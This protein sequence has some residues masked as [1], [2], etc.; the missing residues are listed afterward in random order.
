MQH[1]LGVDPYFFQ[2][3][4]DPESAR[5]LSVMCHEIR[6]PVSVI[7]GIACIL[8]NTGL[9]E[10]QE[11]LLGKMERASGVL[12]S[13]AD[14]VLDFSGLKAGNLILR[15]SVFPL[16]ALADILE[17]FMAEPVQ[18]KG[19]EWRCTRRF[20]S[21]LLVRQDKIKLFELLLNLLRNACKYTVNGS[22][23]LDMAASQQPG[24][25]V[26]DLWFSVADTGVG[27]AEKDLP[28]LFEEFGQIDHSLNASQSGSGLGLPLC[29]RIAEAMGGTITVS[30]QPGKGSC[31]SVSL[32]TI[33]HLS[34][35]G[36]PA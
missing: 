26:T 1:V 3:E 7:L 21:D 15:P 4:Q 23:R 11:L 32:P 9:T 30:S 12:L 10:R 24:S 13:I 27:I 14:D 33:P 16:S 28:K 25:P 29:K 18:A 19:L 20:P 5:L 36:C 2:S 8:R 35:P 17:T 31:F 22:I 6:N 34:E